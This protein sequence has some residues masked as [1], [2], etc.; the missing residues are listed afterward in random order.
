MKEVGRLLSVKQLTTTPHHPQ[1]NGLIEWFTGTLKTMLKQMCTERPKDW[2]RYL[3]AIL[4]AYQES[5]QESLGF[6]PFELLYGRSVNG[7]LQIL[8]QFLTNH[9]SD[10]N[11]WTT[12]QAER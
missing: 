6:A 8:R 2:K 12:S 3:D 4:F 5:P 7:P 9:K 11:V 1:C 10:P